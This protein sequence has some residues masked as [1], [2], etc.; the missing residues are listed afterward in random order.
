[1]PYNATTVRG[2][3]GVL[4]KGQRQGWDD[5]RGKILL[6]IVSACWRQLNSDAY[7]MSC[8]V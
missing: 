6:G 5:G 7:G 1:M 8:R 2:D 4:E 3:L